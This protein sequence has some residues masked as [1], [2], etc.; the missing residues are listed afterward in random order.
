M[1]EG[2]SAL[3]TLFPAEAIALAR[4]EQGRRSGAQSR[5]LLEALAAG[6]L[7]SAELIAV[8]GLSA[9]ERSLRS[10]WRMG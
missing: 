10:S 9:F 6:P 2:L 5:E 7:S 1:T 3:K 8:L 4:P